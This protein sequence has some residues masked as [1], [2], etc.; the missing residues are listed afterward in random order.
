MSCSFFGP[1]PFSP[2]TRPSPHAASS[3]SIVLMP[4]SRVEQGDGLR[5]DALEVEQVENRRRKLLEQIAVIARLAG[6]GDLADLRREVLADAGNRAQ[7]LFGQVRECLGGVRDRFG[8]VPVR[9]NLERVLA[10]DLEQVGDLRKDSRDGQ[11]FHVSLQDA[12]RT[13]SSWTER[14]ARRSRCGTR[15]G[16]PRRRPAPAA[17]QGHPPDRPRR[18]GN[19]RRRRRIPSR[20]ARRPRRRRR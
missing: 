16:A 13:T 19:R 14:E 9:A 4:S 17:P 1:S 20:R 2:R 15:A 6:F 3:S 5:A 10:L 11:V 12:K 8:R 18:T 7:L